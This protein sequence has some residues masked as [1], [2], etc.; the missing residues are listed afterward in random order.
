MKGL[1]D[2]KMDLKEAETL[3][4]YNNCNK[5]FQQISRTN[6]QLEAFTDKL[7]NINERERL[8][9]Q[10]ESIYEQ[11]PKMIKA[12][13]PYYQLWQLTSSFE[14]DKEDWMTKN[15]LSLNYDMVEKKLTGDYQREIM[16][17]LKYFTNIK[18]FVAHGVCEEA[19][20][21]IERF[22]EKLWLIE[23]LTCEGLMKKPNLFKEMFTN[24]GLPYIELKELNLTAI[25]EC[26][27]DKHRGIVE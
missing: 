17:L 23:N 7:N 13:E 14:N 2:I 18:N 8:L 27:L 16:R 9:K 24:A 11:L 3:G 15:I 25:I 10:T 21:A 12:F 19:K 6:F 26:G 20:K 4:P 1:E 5:L 22:K